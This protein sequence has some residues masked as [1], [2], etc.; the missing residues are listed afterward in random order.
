MTKAKLCTAASLLPAVAAFVMVTG[1][2]AAQR[3]KSQRQ[4]APPPASL[5]QAPQ[6]GPVKPYAPPASVTDQLPNGL[7]LIV[8][9]DHRF[10]LVTAILSVRGGSS[11]LPAEDAG[12]AEAEA[13]LLTSGTPTMNALQIAEEGDRFG[14]SID[15]SAGDDFI[16]VSGS[17]LSDRVN[18]MFSLLADVVLHPTFPENEVAL[19]KQN[20]LQELQLDRSEPGFLGVVQFRKLLFGNNP[21]AIV[22]PTEQSIARISRQS[23]QQFH[24]RVFLPNNQAVL[25]IAGD[26]EHNAARALAERYFREW[27]FGRPSFP[28]APAPPQI[29]ARRIYIVDRPG[30]AQS[31]IMLGN[32]GITRHSPDFFPFLVAN[33]ILGGSFNSRLIADVREEKGYAYGIYSV[34]RP[35]LLLGDWTVGTQVRTAV[36]GPALEEIFKDLNEFRAAPPTSTEMEQAKNYLAGSFT[37]GLQ[38]QGSV[39]QQFLTQTIYQMPNDYLATWVQRVEAVTP[40]EALAAAR[41]HITPEN[42]VVVI[43]GDAKII[44]PSVAKLTAEPLIVYNETGKQIGTYPAAGTAAGAQ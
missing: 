23:L 21:Y 44:E 41:R 40:E 8:I 43:V 11:V 25:V 20:M 42:E 4:V 32:L 29:A 30:S 33:E 28:P 35:K 22:A 12:L 13:D 1:V 18:R 19:R 36:T 37:E 16:Q 31:N 2:A 15:A 9:E 34:N 14:G 39:A 3:E 24:D 17:C 7:R 27:P 5:A 38:T 26:I 10:P 6:I